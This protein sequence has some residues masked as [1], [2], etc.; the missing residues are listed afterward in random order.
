MIQFLKEIFGYRRASA[1]DKEDKRDFLAEK[2]DPVPHL[3]ATGERSILPPI[4]AQDQGNTKQCVGFMGAAAG[5][6]MLTAKE[7]RMVTIEGNLVWNA[8]L[9]NGTADEEKGDYIRSAA[10]AICKL[11]V[12]TNRGR[13]FKPKRYFLVKRTEE[14]F[15]QRILNGQ[16]IMTGFKILRPMT[17]LVTWFW[18]A[19][20]RGGGH[21]ILIYDFC[22]KR[23]AFVAL[24][25]WGR[26]GY[27]G[28]GCFFIKYKDIDKLFSCFVFSK[29]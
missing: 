27:K 23:K 2:E 21:A 13:F 9:A 6:I 16:P 17:S 24:N 26:Y 29:D 18:R 10:K 4:Y 22:D 8:Q 19:T 12:K 1:F 15:K 3:P 14:S 20:R 28:S 5:S 7:R 11:G 25:S